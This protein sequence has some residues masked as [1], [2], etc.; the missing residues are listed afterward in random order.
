MGLAAIMAVSAMSISAFAKE[1]IYDA[2][3]NLT[4]YEYTTDDISVEKLKELSKNSEIIYN[5]KPDNGMLR[6][7]NNITYFANAKSLAGRNVTEVFSVPRNS[8]KYTNTYISPNNY[9]IY[10]AF[11]DCTNITTC[12]VSR[13]SLNSSN[14]SV[15]LDEWTPSSNNVVGR[16]Y[17]INPSLA[18]YFQ[19]K[20]NPYKDVSGDFFITNNK[21]AWE[22]KLN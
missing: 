5:N 19:L 7:G 21:T 16:S 22:N 3:G 8:V 6:M 20:T 18:Y 4:G 9:T 13:Y 17:T 1:A 12:T 11:I 14:S 2:N 10:T 15:Y